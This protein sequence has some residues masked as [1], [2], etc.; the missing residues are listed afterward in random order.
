M[1]RRYEFATGAPWQGQTP[2]ILPRRVRRRARRVEGR[3][4]PDDQLVDADQPLVHP[5]PSAEAQ[6]RSRPPGTFPVEGDLAESWTQPSDTTYVFKLR[7]GVRWHGKPPVN[8]RELTADDV[9]CTYE[10]AE[11]AVLL[12]PGRPGADRNMDRAPGGRRSFR[13]SP[14]AGSLI[15]TGPWML[16]RVELNVRSTPVGESHQRLGAVRHELHAESRQRL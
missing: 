12:V 3:P 16:E 9:K 1:A 8:G 2:R 4:A 11:G 13:R 10:H 6:S 7:R 5:Q 15:G 14:E